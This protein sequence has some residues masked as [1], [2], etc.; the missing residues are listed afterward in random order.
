MTTP[1][2]DVVI[3][4][5][6]P[7]R[8][9]ARAVSSVLDGAVCGIRVTVVCHNVDT[10]AIAGALGHLA[11][12]PQVRLIG[13]RDETA[14]P[15]GPI[16]AGLDAASAPFTALLDSDDSY[17]RGAVDAWMAVQRRDDADAVVPM[18][19][20]SEGPS[21]R[22]PPTRPGRTR[23]LDGA[24][25]RLAYRSRQHGL[26]STARFGDVRMT[27]GLTTGEDVAQS[28]A[29]WYSGARISF[30][31]NEPGYRIHVD[32]GQRT[33]AVRKPAADS[34]A[35]LD[36][37]L[38][39]AFVDTLDRHQR[40]SFAVKLL[41]THIMDVLAA[42]IEH[43]QQT[44]IAAIATAVARIEAIAPLAL[45]TV[46]ARDARILRAVRAT[47]AD[48]TAIGAELSVRTDFRR[49]SNL[50]PAR[51]TRLLHREAPLRF[52]GAVALSP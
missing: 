4:V 11:D 50:V 47:T 27:P 20:Y 10:A 8:P 29:I 13:F 19:R 32:G 17:D 42:A 52:L 36:A 44:D 3:P 51:A 1:Q 15:A 16:N 30:A 38:D 43:G 28:V 49:P 39:P 45:G 33:S 35:F 6:T 40:E 37:V 7:E 5:H 48:L 46:S 23:R 14:S 9:I 24:R 25:D 34:L 18:L 12:S 22:T 2:V 26:V 41:R 31:R 21:T